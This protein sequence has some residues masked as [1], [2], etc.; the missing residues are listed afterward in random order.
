MSVANPA[1]LKPD[2]IEIDLGDCG[3]CG[4]AIGRHRRVNR[5]GAPDFFCDD[6]LS[7]DEM[8]LPELERRAELRRQE[9]TAAILARWDELDRRLAKRLP[10]RETN[11][12]SRPAASTV[13]AFRYLTAAG[14]VARL[15]GW[16]ADRPKDAPFLLALLESQAPC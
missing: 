2:P 7:P 8:T 13:D 10:P 9:E 15:R 5:P 1:M 14:D 11:S 12:E 3:L 4:L 6:D 16:L